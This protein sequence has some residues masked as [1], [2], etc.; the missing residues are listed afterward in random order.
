M[1]ST[2]ILN[3]L[4]V[5]MIAAVLAGGLFFL[6]KPCRAMMLIAAGRARGCPVGEAL[7]APSNQDAAQERIAQASRVVREDPAGYEMW[8]TPKGSY[9]MPKNDDRAQLPNILAEHERHIYGSG[10]QGVKAGDVVL[11][12]GA[13]VGTFTR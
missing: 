3:L 1:R 6:C 2:R 7:Q 8:E 9:W 12:C 10:E 13:H 5:A 4:S 11:D